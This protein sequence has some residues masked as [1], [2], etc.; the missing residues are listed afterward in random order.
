MSNLT[1]N[2]KFLRMEQS[3]E[4]FKHSE[5][6]NIVSEKGLNSED[7]LTCSTPGI[8]VNPFGLNLEKLQ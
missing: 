7:S 6:S 8:G 3:A 1:P 5:Y 4:A 2:D